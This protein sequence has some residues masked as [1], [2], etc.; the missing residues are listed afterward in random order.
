MLTLT[1]LAVIAWAGLLLSPWQ[2]HRTREKLE[3]QTASLVEGDLSDVT[4]VIPARNEAA[5][6]PETLTRIEQQGPGIRVIVVD[7]DSSDDTAA[8]AMAS[9]SVEVQVVKSEPLPDGWAGKLWAL[10]QG[11][12][13]VKTPL[14][15]LLDADIGLMDGILPTMRSKLRQ[16]GLDFLSLMAQLRMSSFWERLLM[17]AYIYFFK[18]LYPFSLA[19]SPRSKVAAAAGG[20]VLLR[21][22]VLKKLGGFAV[23]KSALIDDC[24][25]AK[26][27]KGLG[28]RT[29]IGLTRDAKSLRPYDSLGS[30][31]D[32]VARSAFT[33]LGY[34][35]ILL[36]LVT[37]VFGIVF[38]VPFLALFSQDAT[39]FSL[40]AAAVFCMWFGY[41]P[42]LRYYEQPVWLVLAL[43][44][45]GLLYLLMTWSSAASHW[46]GS[47][48]Q[49]KG[50]HYSMLDSDPIQR[51]DASI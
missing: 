48:A 47:G 18:L 16:E 5:V 33:Q 1:V 28:F 45:I 46:F 24:T 43:P 41:L 37:I 38:F 49:W 10:E 36:G 44:L 25:L 21:V 30:I 4:V 6:L 27:V 29:W 11:V 8:V 31:W 26:K 14:V 19:N 17:P 23:L 3:A 32:L 9:H 20:C 42:T 39:I 2:A 13:E 35:S 15:L 12:A 7:D 40:G 50:R 34:S 22:E 51:K